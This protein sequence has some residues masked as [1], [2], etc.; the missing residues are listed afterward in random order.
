M[1]SVVSFGVQFYLRLSRTVNGLAP[2]SV[3]ITVAGIRKSISLN[4]KVNVASWMFRE[5]KLKGNDSDTR[6]INSYVNEVR[7]KLFECKRQLILDKK[8]VTLDS[9]WN[10]FNLQ[11]ILK[12]KERDKLYLSKQA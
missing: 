9:I 12:A 5:E 11:N 8:T 4:H 3:R 10:K 7:S 6:A 2:L 1:R